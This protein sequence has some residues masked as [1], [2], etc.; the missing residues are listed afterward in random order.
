MKHHPETLDNL[1]EIF[2]LVVTGPS[3]FNKQRAI[4]LIR[5]LNDVE[6]RDLRAFCQNLD[7]LVETVW[8][9]ELREKRIREDAL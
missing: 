7:N 1:I 8:M 6:R 5:K 9:A 3:D 2:S 4:K